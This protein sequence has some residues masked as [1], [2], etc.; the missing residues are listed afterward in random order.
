MLQDAQ[1]GVQDAMDGD[2]WGWHSEQSMMVFGLI[3]AMLAVK[4]RQC[5]WALAIGTG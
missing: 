2:H 4:F 1:A 3:A 5:S